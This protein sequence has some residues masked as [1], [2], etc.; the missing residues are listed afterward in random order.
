MNAGWI[1]WWVGNEQARTCGLC[2][3]LCG[4]EFPPH[5]KCWEPWEGLPSA[6]LWHGWVNTRGGA[7]PPMGLAE[8]VLSAVR[9]DSMRGVTDGK[10]DVS[11]HFRRW[12]AWVE[13]G[14]HE[15]MDR[16]RSSIVVHQLHG[17]AAVEAMILRPK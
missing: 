12:G 8:Y 11:A 3:G 14:G 6:M 9:L 1:P 17:Y 7:R 15:S 5:V 2:G 10:A 4:Y 13:A 16:L